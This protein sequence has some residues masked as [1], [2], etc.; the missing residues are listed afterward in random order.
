MRKPLVLHLILKH[1]YFDAIE[2]GKQRVE[3]RDN[4][5]Y[6]RKRIVEKWDCNGGNIV[7]FHKGYTKQTMSFKIKLLVLYT[8]KIHLHLGERLD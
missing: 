6:W 1:K 8:D 5:P 4:T 2:Q 3:H 7:V